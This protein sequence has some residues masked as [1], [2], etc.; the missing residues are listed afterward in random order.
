MAKECWKDND[1]TE[2]GFI[3]LS[4]CAEKLEALGLTV[5]EIESK[6]LK[7]HICRLSG[8]CSAIGGEIFLGAKTC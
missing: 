1:I 4:R 3:A 6:A 7:C 5:E 8:R 2:E